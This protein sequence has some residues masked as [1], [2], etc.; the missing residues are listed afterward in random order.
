MK[1]VEFLVVQGKTSWPYENILPDFSCLSTSV[2]GTLRHKKSTVSSLLNPKKMYD[3]VSD[4]KFNFF[5]VCIRELI[6]SIIYLY[7]T[8]LCLSTFLNIVSL[9]KFA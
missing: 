8:Y 5:Y 1:W 9:A 6:Y 4:V 3:E 7:T 2:H